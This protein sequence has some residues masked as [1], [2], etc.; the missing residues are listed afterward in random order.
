MKRMTFMMLCAAFAAPAAAVE[1]NTIDLFVRTERSFL[2]RTPT[3]A[4]P[5]ISWTAPSTAVSA[6]LSVRGFEGETT[7]DVSDVSTFRMEFETPAS[8]ETENV[9]DLTLTFD[10]GASNVVRRGQIGVV[11]GTGTFGA[12]GASAGLRATDGDWAV[13]KARRAVLPVPA[14]TTEFTI[15]GTTVET[16]LGGAA[17]WYGWKKISPKPDRAP[18][19]LTLT[20][21]EVE[22]TAGIVALA[23]GFSLIVR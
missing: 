4:A 2:W 10:C 21:G 19:V 22:W 18:Y 16:G 5:E 7:Y 23:K 9:Y 15:D 6:T 13:L 11:R 1:S 12:D 20:A 14:G 17:G 8:A 3:D